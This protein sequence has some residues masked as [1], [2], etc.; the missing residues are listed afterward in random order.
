M[1]LFPDAAI[2]VLGESVNI[3]SLIPVV[4]SFCI[5]PMMASCSALNI[6]D[7]SLILFR[8]DC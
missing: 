4:G 2:M 8:V 7:W 1:W 3:T 5:A 6:D